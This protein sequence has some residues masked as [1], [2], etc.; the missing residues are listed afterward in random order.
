[1]MKLVYLAV[2]I[3]RAKMAM[4]ETQRSIDL[5]DQ[6]IKELGER[7]A[8]HESKIARENNALVLQDLDIE[9][10]KLELEALE[11]KLHPVRFNPDDESPPML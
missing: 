7:R 4:L 5:H 6:R 8:L 3:A 11:K 1:M 2:S 10:K 9:I